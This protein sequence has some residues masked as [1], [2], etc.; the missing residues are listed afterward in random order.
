LDAHESP[1]LTDQQI[2]DASPDQLEDLVE[3][4]NLALRER[5]L[6]GLVRDQQRDVIPGYLAPG[7]FLDDPLDNP[8]SE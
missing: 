8:A 4:I 5:G 3:Q 2:R 6:P 1:L 7:D